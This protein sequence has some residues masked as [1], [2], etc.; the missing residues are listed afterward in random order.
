MVH[1]HLLSTNKNLDNWTNTVQLSIKTNDEDIFFS[2]NWRGQPQIG[3][4]QNI[5]E[6]KM[7]KVPDTFVSSVKFTV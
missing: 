1:L 4:I 2:Q 6:P 5:D 3:D 7:L